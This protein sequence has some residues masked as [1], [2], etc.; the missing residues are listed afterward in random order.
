MLGLGPDEFEQ[1]LSGRLKV[2]LTR[3]LKWKAARSVKLARLSSTPSIGFPVGRPIGKWLIEAKK[4]MC[5]CPDPKFLVLE[6]WD[7]EVSHQD[8]QRRRFWAIPTN[9]VRRASSARRIAEPRLALVGTTFAS[10]FAASCFV[11][12]YFDAEKG[13]P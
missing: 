8:R 4:S 13:R 6:C 1:E 9:R 12:S 5:C 10:C 3:K 2:G 7:Q 11:A